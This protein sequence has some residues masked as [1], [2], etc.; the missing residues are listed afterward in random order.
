MTNT[1]LANGGTYTGQVTGNPSEVDCCYGF[2]QNGTGKKIFANGIVEEGIFVD[3][4]IHK[5]KVTIPDPEGL[6]L[7]VHEG[8]FVYGCLNSH[9]KVTAATFSEEG[10]FVG[11]ELNG[12]GKVTYT[13]KGAC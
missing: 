10:N 7:E 3:D 12:P 9:G 6:G 1:E 11:G 4:S 5:G 8:V 13:E 2:V